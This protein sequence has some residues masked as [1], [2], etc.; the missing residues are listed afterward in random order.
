MSELMP[1]LQVF[2]PLFPVGAYTLSNGMETYTQ[3]G[4]VR[5]RGSLSDYLASFLAVLPYG[6]LGLAAHAALGGDAAALDAVCNA[7]KAPKELR[8]GSAHLASRFIK[9]VTPLFS[10]PELAAYG[11]LVRAGD[12]RGH[13]S[14]AAG[15]FIRDTGADTARGLEIYCYSLLA[16]AVNHAAKLVPLRQGDAQGALAD[17]AVRISGAA[18]LALHTEIDELGVSG[19]GFELRAMQHESLYTRLYAS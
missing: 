9:A 4:I 14:V 16:A 11:E 8:D 5:D 17:A 1:L 19:A 2:D 3:K 7:M 10:C 6:D 15:L 13:Y 18:A 12:C